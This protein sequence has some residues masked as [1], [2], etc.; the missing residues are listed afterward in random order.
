MYLHQLHVTHVRNL[1]AQEIELDP[2]FNCLVGPNGAGKTAVLE[3]IA[4]L[5]RGR[6]FRTSRISS[7]IRHGE[8]E[9][10]VRGQVKSTGHV[11]H[12]LAL[13]KGRSGQ[14]RIQMDGERCRRI[15]DFARHL[16]IQTIL[17]DVSELIY[18][19]PS[20]R[21]NFLDWGLFHVEPQYLRQASSFRRV[22]A[23]RNAWLKAHG[24]GAEL[25]VWNERYLAEAIPLNEMRAEYVRNL[26]LALAE[27]GESA[28][29][30][31]EVKLDYDWGGL[32]STTEAAKKLSESGARDVK[33]G[34]TH[35]GPHR[36]DL[37][38]ATNDRAAAEVMSRGQ[39]KL[40]A[41]VLNLAQAVV[42]ERH[43]SNKGIFL[44]DDFGAE[45]DQDH[46]DRFL[47][48]LL[49]MQCQI[50]ATSTELPVDR[51]EWV[52]FRDRIHMFHVKQGTVERT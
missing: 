50:V 17:P 51:P 39:A 31:D 29:L 26:N 14:T 21:R 35:R 32:Q 42:L 25:D 27:V 34:S 1:A 28:G 3:S 24:G 37:L 52:R 6:S 13:S 11:S 36:G 7:L 43:T 18:G 23:Q 46:W 49:G 5:S 9:L 16:P 33:L 15:S 47:S 19:A 2:G 44:I 12:T 48:V 45:L 20:G 40:L 8:A 38:V 10:V 22:L 4:L 41:C 30:S